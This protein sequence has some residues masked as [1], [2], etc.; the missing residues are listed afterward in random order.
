VLAFDPPFDLLVT[1][2]DALW[3]LASNPASEDGYIEQASALVRDPEGRRRL[4]EEFA[5]RIRS[6]HV[7]DEWRRRLDAIYGRIAGMEHDPRPIAVTQCLATDTDLSLSE[8]QASKNEATSPSVDPDQ[9]WRE[10]ILTSAYRA[11]E[12]GD[13]RGAFDILGRSIRLRRFDGRILL[14]IAKLVPHWVCRRGRTG[15]GNSVS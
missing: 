2:A 6:C 14:A 12:M 9:G 3:S 13:Y 5:R 7:G 10:A 4:G 8:W 11:R 15:E 1:N